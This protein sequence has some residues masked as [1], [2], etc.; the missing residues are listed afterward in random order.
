MFNGFK[1]Y[2]TI[3]LYSHQT[4]LVQSPK[5][6][7]KSCQT[8]TLLP[9]RRT[10]LA[11][12]TEWP[13]AVR[14]AICPPAS[15]HLNRR[16]W[17]RPWRRRSAVWQFVRCVIMPSLSARP[18]RWRV[19]CVQCTSSMICLALETVTVCCVLDSLRIC[20]SS[21]V[22]WRVI[23]S[24]CNSRIQLRICMCAIISNLLKVNLTYTVP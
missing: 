8:Q 13:Q 12:Q 17:P 3:C 10:H 7:R 1:L 14:A 15:K 16:R 19:T 2:I 21:L 9:H 22:T 5:S 20:P 24:C 11:R 4:P 6:S 23:I 18:L